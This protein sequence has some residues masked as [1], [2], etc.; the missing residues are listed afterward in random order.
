M[1]TGA[2]NY[3]GN[4]FPLRI[5]GINKGRGSWEHVWKTQSIRSFRHRSRVNIKTIMK[6]LGADFINGIWDYGFEVPK[7]I[8]GNL[9]DSLVE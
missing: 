3:L 5:R 9:K 1:S 6:G 7:G 8:L 4:R 2:T